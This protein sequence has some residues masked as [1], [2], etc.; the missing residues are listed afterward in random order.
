MRGGYRSGL[1]ASNETTDSLG[2][3]AGVLVAAGVFLVL[4][5]ALA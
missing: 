2:V 5:R 4:S 1:L 3:S